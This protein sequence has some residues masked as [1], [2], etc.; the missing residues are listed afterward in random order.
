MIAYHDEKR[1]WLDSIKYS[2][3]KY[4]NFYNFL[5]WLIS[6]VFSYKKDSYKRIVKY[7]T[8]DKNAIILNI[9]SGPFKLE[10]SFINLDIT[11]FSNVHIV[12]D[13]TQLPFK[14]NSIDAIVNIVILEHVPKPEKGVDEMYRVMKNKGV[15]Y[16][17][18][19]FMQG[20]HASPHDYKRWTSS[21]ISQLH[22]NF[23]ELECGVGAGPTSSLVWIL[24]EWLALF[25][26]F[27]IIPLYKILFVMFTLILWPIKFIDLILIEHPMAKNIAS[28]FY[29]IG[30]KEKDT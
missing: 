3:K 18:I 30:R 21:G 12:A 15:I 1:D 5:I 6:P 9:G 7:V 14:N 4:P 11:P 26:S 8:N 22:H 19:P 17:H 16:T 20:F 23:I 27:R 29:Y 25:L 10:K 2:F 24:T 28:T 13:A